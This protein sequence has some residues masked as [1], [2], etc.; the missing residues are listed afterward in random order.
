M[1]CAA[2]VAIAGALF[3][4]EYEF[5]ETLPIAAGPLLGLIMAEVVVSMGRHRSRTM[6]VMVAVG[7]AVAIV[8]AGHI[9][10]NEVGPVKPGV[11]LSAAGA[12][13]LGGLRTMP[14]RADRKPPADAPVIAPAADPPGPHT[15]NRPP[16]P[17]AAPPRGRGRQLSPASR[18]QSPTPPTPR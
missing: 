14:W 11:Y 5:D 17:D 18:R 2:A 4:G 1:T 9:D 12:A 3:L 16:A 6:A 8:L 10:A 7:A 13:L 15:S